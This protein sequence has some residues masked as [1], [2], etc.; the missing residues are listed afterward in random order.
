[1]S[2][3]AKLFGDPHKK[4]LKRLQPIVHAVNALEPEWQKKSDAQLQEQTDRFR[5]QIAKGTSLDD[6]L[7]EAFATVREAAKRVLNMRHF[8]VQLLGGAALHKRTIAEMRTGEGKTLTSTLPVYLNALE[9]RGVHVVTVNEYLAQRDAEWMGQLYTFLGLSVGVAV[10]DMDTQSKQAAYA[11]DIT[12]GTNNEFGFD[13][14]RDNMAVDRN[15]QVQRGL[16]FALIDEIDSVLID[17]ARTPL[18]ISAPDTRDVGSY[19]TYARLVPQL[20]EGEHYNVDEKLRSSTLTDEGIH[21]LERLLNIDN[22]YEEKGIVTVHHIEQA[23]KA[24]TLFKKDKHYVVKDG[25]IIIIDEFTGRMMPGRRYSE[26]LHQAIEAKEG[27]TIQ[28]HSRTMAT[29]T[30]QN[31]FRQ[32]EKLAGMTG[33]AETEAEEFLEIYGLETL[34]IPTNK[35]IARVDH[36][37]R[38]YQSEKG[39]FDSAIA[40]IRE[41]HTQRQPILVGT[42][43]VEKNER[44]ASLLLEAKIPHN[45]LNAKNHE[46][47]AEI[48]AQA[49]APGAVTLATNMAG[50]GVDIVLGGVDGT[51]EDKEL[52]KQ[53]GGL[54]VLGTER[55]ESRR[56]DNQLRGRAGRQGDPGES[57]FLVSAEDD[58]LRVFGNERMKTTMAALKIPEDQPIENRIIT[59]SLETAQKRV[60]GFN[61]DRRKHV[62]KY[63][64]VMNKHR[65]V[66]Y[67]RRFGILMSWDRAKSED[68]ALREVE[69]EPIAPASELK[70]YTTLRERIFDLFE[71]ELDRVISRHASADDI[72]DWNIEEMIETVHTITPLPHNAREHIDTI[73][74]QAD[75]GKAA[76][77]ARTEIID[78]FLGHIREAYAAKEAEIG[79]DMMRRIERMI[80]LRSIDALW[81]DHLEAMQALREGVSLR[82]YGQ[83]DPLVEYKKEGFQQFQQLLEDVQKRVVYSVLKVTI[84]PKEDAS[85]MQQAQRMMQRGQASLQARPGA[86][87]L[88][89]TRPLQATQGSENRVASAS[90]TIRPT[91]AVKA[92]EPGRNDPCPCGSGKKYK[93]CHG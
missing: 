16:H 76:A 58:L 2:R 3:L 81:I 41:K 77:Q 55:H 11:C 39:K 82:G 89:A 85:P 43:S 75:K 52:V 18:I 87:S 63:D 73:R 28:K 40:I 66:I 10:R 19:A 69:G 45:V 26:G 13:Y 5:E 37:D 36:S 14:L 47:E 54:F 70:Q 34:V 42:A 53:L 17:E 93:K 62:L 46:R 27:V 60:E 44:L 1:M 91:N 83:R 35:P 8:D 74:Q 79:S 65:E 21:T 48:I 50:R 33:T 51:Q 80:L 61:F 25:E 64:D 7:P 6:M 56:I 23:L 57:Q 84:Q 31:Y 22:I 32:Y 68:E 29:I 71:A 59:R 86:R 92:H 90:G 20:K 24:H 72:D 38:I 9:G 67:K 12:Y 30:F 15:R 88:H 49:G 78:H 4:Q